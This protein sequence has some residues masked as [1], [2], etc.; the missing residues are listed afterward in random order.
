MTLKVK[1]ERELYPGA[2]KTGEGEFVFTSSDFL[3][4]MDA[5]NKMK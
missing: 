3:K 2:N 1:K 4:I 5:F